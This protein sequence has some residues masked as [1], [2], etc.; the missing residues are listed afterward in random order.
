METKIACTANSTEFSISSTLVTEQRGV[1]KIIQSKE[2]H[3]NF[4]ME[5]STQFFKKLKENAKEKKGPPLC[6]MGFHYKAGRMTIFSK[7]VETGLTLVVFVAEDSVKPFFQNA[8]KK[9]LGVNTFVVLLPYGSRGLVISREWLRVFGIA[10]NDC[11][12]KWSDDLRDYLDYF[13]VLD[14]DV[15]L[16]ERVDWIST[17]NFILFQDELPSVGYYM[18]D[19]LQQSDYHYVSISPSRNKRYLKRQKKTKEDRDLTEFISGYATK[20]PEQFYCVKIDCWLKAHYCPLVW[21]VDE[22]NYV[23]RTPD[24]F[25]LYTFFKKSI[26]RPLNTLVFKQAADFGFG[27]QVNGFLATNFCFNEF[28]SSRAT[29]SAAGTSSFATPIAICLT[30]K[31][32]LMLSEYLLNYDDEE[33]ERIAK[34]ECSSFF[35]KIEITTVAPKIEKTMN[36][37]CRKGNCSN[38]KCSKN[39]EKC[40]NRCK[41]PNNCKNR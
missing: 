27:K 7:K 28:Q 39:N 2:N 31:Q 5:V 3:S 11:C 17:E 26:C 38:C 16:I 20:R 22:W 30:P 35:K 33:K 40:G 18:K 8:Q 41:C 25:I 13:L 29:S 21:L 32:R 9:N 4:K 10:I 14:D 19:L 24:L 12:K 37:G 1:I 34:K 23:E 6:L 15:K 36:C